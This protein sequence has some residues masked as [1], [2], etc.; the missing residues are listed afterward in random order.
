ML[1]WAIALLGLGTIKSEMPPQPETGPG[2]YGGTSPQKANIE[3]CPEACSQSYYTRGWKGFECSTVIG[4]GHW[5][6]AITHEFMV[7]GSIRWA[8]QQTAQVSS[9]RARGVEP[10]GCHLDR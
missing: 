9:I 5:H 8:L 6:A 10:N 1:A 3:I 7:A 4:V 2:V